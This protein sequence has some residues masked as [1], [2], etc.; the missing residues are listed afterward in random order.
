MGAEARRAGMSADDYIAGKAAPEQLLAGARGGVRQ[1]RGRLRDLE[2]AVGRHQ[3]L[4]APHRRHRP[5]VQRRGAEHSGRLHVGAVGLAGLVRRARLH[6]YEEDVRHQR[7]QLRRRGRV[8]RP[9][10]GQGRH[11]R[12][13]ERRSRRRRT[14]TIR[15]SGTARAT[16]GTCTSTARSWRAT[17]S[18]STIRV[19]PP[20]PDTILPRSRLCVEGRNHYG[21]RLAITRGEAGLPCS[22]PVSSGVREIRTATGKGNA[23]RRANARAAGRSTRVETRILA[24]ARISAIVAMLDC[25]TAHPREAV[26]G[27]SARRGC[28]PPARWSLH[29]SL[30]FSRYVL[31]LGIGPH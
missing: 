23:R 8:R 25:A 26:V 19:M 2:D 28:A 21:T 30:R 18:A 16:C 9:R 1:A 29:A 4:P 15:R 24:R 22:S 7:Q 10:A 27:R 5:A 12:R 31:Y 14:S 6:G 13:R 20:S 3:P 11:G 17:S